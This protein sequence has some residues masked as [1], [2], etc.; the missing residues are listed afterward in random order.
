MRLFKMHSREYLSTVHNL[1][2]RLQQVQERFDKWRVTG[3]SAKGLYDRFNV[4]RSIE[5]IVRSSNVNSVMYY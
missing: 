5:Q 1:H 4:A 3:H 2:V